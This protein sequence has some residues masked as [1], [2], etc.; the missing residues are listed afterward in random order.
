MEAQ[1]CHQPHADQYL[2]RGVRE[3]NLNQQHLFDR[4][5]SLPHEQ[6]APV[7]IPERSDDLQRTAQSESEQ[8]HLNA[9]GREAGLRLS[10]HH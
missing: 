4:A 5:E 1:L 9:G 10:G 3:R 2:Y 6:S 7:H 8:Q